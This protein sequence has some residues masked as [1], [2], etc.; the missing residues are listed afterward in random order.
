MSKYTVK[1]PYRLFTPGPVNVPAE[2][3]AVLN[4]GL[5]YHREDAFVKLYESVRKGLKK[6]LQTKS[7]VHVLTSS[8]TGAME[9]AVCNLVG[10]GDKA[11]VLT[12]GRFGERWR[13]MAIR[14]GAYAET[15]ARPYGEAIPPVEVERALLANDGAK[16]VFATLTETSTGVLSDIRAYGE[17]CRRLNRVLVVDGVAGIGADEFRMDDWKVDCAVGGSQKALAMPPG[18]SYISVNERAWELVEKT[19][20]TRFYFDLRSCRKYAARGQ[21]PWTPAISLVY[22][23]DMVLKRVNQSGVQKSW[24]E[25]KAMAEYVRAQVGKLGLTFFPQ[26]PS[27][28]LTVI[29]MPPGVDG[30]ELVLAC[31]KDRMLFANGQGDLKGKIVRIGHMGPVKKSDMAK[32]LAVFTKHFLQLKRRSK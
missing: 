6:L 23:M 13:E 31:K 32:A 3:L 21:T 11:L 4:S 30:A 17:I 12:A 19:K 18:L 16:C 26:R 5:V 24:R 14:F 27:N 25:H 20:R 1:P 28:A 22:V 15:L 9:A 8:G 2:V 29:N 10:P 7:E